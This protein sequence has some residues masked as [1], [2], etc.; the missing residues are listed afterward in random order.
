MPLSP[1]EEE[2]LARYNSLLQEAEELKRAGQFYEAADKR[3]EAAKI[4]AYLMARDP[5]V[6]RNPQGKYTGGGQTSSDTD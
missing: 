5:V 4:L 2:F 1:R 3:R 6:G